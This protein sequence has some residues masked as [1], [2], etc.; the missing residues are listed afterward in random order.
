[1]GPFTPGPNSKVLVTPFPYPAP[2]HLA[3][4]LSYLLSPSGL[5]NEETFPSKVSESGDWGSQFLQPENSTPC[6]ARAGRE[7]M[8]GSE[9]QPACRVLT[10][11]GPDVA[12]QQP[13]PGEGLPAGATHAGQRVASDVHLESTQA[14]ILLVAVFAV[15]GLARLGVFGHGETGQLLGQLAQAWE[16]SITLGLQGGG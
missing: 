14:D 1:M 8:G 13:G 5:M 6:L 2:T 11:V 12:L 7:G 3:E 15:E 9:R 10:G 4:E 16:G